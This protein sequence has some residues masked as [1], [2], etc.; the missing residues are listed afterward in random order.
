MAIPPPEFPASILMPVD[1]WS[2]LDGVPAP[3][4]VPPSWIGPHV[5][6]RLIEALRTLRKLPVNGSPAGF[7][8]SWPAFQPEYSER[9]SYE[10]D[11]EWKK[12]Q[13]ALGNRIRPRP[14]S[15]EIQRME[16]CI[17]WPGRY[18]GAWPQLLL[19]VSQAAMSRSFHRD[20]RHAA[21]R[22]RLPLRTARRRNRDG[23]DLIAAGLRSD[24][25][26]VF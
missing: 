16:I 20:L 6:L 18:L 14:S 21:R 9:A 19:A 15:I 13:L 24:A 5:G 11:D 25:V 8:N 17:I 7:F 12:D 2:P 10:D 26:P 4:Y 22:L 1:G 3:E 23:L